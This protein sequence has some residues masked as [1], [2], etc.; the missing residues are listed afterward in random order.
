M[1]HRIP[2]LARLCKEKYARV[3]FDGFSPLAFGHSY[4]PDHH[5]LIPLYPILLPLPEAVLFF[6]GGVLSSS[7]YSVPCL[8]WCQR[9][10]S[11]VLHHLLLTPV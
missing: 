7:Y 6:G 5:I 1:A 11:P 2:L 8:L 3:S 4:L 9:G 10:A